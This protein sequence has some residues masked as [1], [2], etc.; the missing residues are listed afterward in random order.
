MNTEDLITYSVV[1]EINK[2][3]GATIEF[4]SDYRKEDDGVHC[5][6]EF[7]GEL[8]R[9]QE[10]CLHEF[11]KLSK[12]ESMRCV[13]LVMRKCIKDLP[14]LTLPDEFDLIELFKK[15]SLLKEKVLSNCLIFSVN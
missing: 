2:A 14:D 12:E 6:V 3:Y 15:E 13:E 10:R 11:T 5:Y 7:K 8:A 1:N 4:N 9:I